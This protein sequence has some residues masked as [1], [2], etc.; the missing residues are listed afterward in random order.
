VGVLIEA[1]GGENLESGYMLSIEPMKGRVLFDR[2]PS[3]MD[4]LW[5]SLVL[6]ERHGINVA[7]E[8]EAPLVERPLAFAPADGRYRVQLLR[9]GSAVE[10]YVA[11][12]VVASYRV[13]ESSGAAWGLFL[14]EGVARFRDLAFRR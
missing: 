13:C 8:I 7:P 1:K 9:K 11:E 4:P 12:Q 10:C 6:N 3:A 14:Q 5:D 2:W